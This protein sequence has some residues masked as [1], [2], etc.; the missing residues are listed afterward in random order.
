[1]NLHDDTV[2]RIALKAIPQVGA[3]IAR[4]L[5]SYCGSA[6]AVFAEKP[7]LLLKI[8]GVGPKVVAN[9]RDPDILHQAE[10]ELELV[11]RHSIDVLFYLDP[12]YPQRLKHIGQAPVLLYAKGHMDLNAARVI[13]IV[14][15]RKPT[16]YGRAACERIVEEL[17][18]CAP[19]IISGLAYGVD[20]TAHRKAMQCGLQTVGVMGSGLG[21]VYPHHHLADTRRMLQNGGLV[22]EFGFTTKPDRENFPARNRIVAGLADVVLVVESARSG[23]SMITAEFANVYNREVCALPGRSIDEQSVG[24]NQLIR[25]N[26]A[27]L[28]TSGSDI[29]TLLDWEGGTAVQAELFASLSPDEG[30]LCEILATTGECKIDELSRR[31]KMTAG[32]LATVLLS[33]EL[34]GVVRPLPGKRYTRIS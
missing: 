15:T 18:D 10:R 33:L 22:T 23:G 31:S 14:G 11:V 24:C 13:A 27:H 1:M 3:V 8:P 32:Q 30:L 17:S 20:I 21:R 2:Y 26:K 4:N 29:A 12:N 5:I 16:A 28:V 6:R 25:N 19:L 34:K 9:I 7:R